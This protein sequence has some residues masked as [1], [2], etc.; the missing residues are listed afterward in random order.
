MFS[1]R[2]ILLVSVNCLCTFNTA[3]TCIQNVFKSKQ[4]WHCRDSDLILKQTTLR[5]FDYKDYQPL[6]SQTSPNVA[7]KQQNTFITYGVNF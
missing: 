5:P 7:M 1:V 3:S 4:H 2:W 6:K